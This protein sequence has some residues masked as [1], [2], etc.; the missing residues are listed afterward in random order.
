MK[1]IS[2]SRRK[3]FEKLLDRL[4]QNGAG[5]AV[6]CY[7]NV[8]CFCLPEKEYKAHAEL[9]RS[10]GAHVESDVKVRLHAKEIV[11]WGIKKM[12]APDLWKTTTGNEIK[13]AVIDTGISRRHPD[14]RGQVKGGI[15]FI[16]GAGKPS[17]SRGH[18]THVAGTI[19]ALLNGRGVV[20][21][22][23]RASLYDIRAFY[24]DGTADL[25]TIIAGI[26]WAVANRMDVINMSFGIEENSPALHAAIKRAAAAGIYLVA[27]AGNNGGALEYPAR[28]PEVI[29]VGAIDKQGKLASFSSRGRGMDVAAPGVNIY[30]TWPGGKYRS[31]DG[32]SMAAAHISGM[33]ALQLASKNRK[34]SARRIKHYLRRSL[35]A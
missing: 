31:L 7:E 4:R 27:S 6:T 34:V 15:D 12:G 26:N 33:T 16:K 17:D 3:A 22:A 32:T 1:L 23:P 18:G 24:P 30:S 28:Y 35:P 29:A 21:M 9:F 25:R 20:G 11:P 13:V 14:L 10:F 5:K 8:W 2:I 19:A